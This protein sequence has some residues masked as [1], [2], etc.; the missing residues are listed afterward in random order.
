MTSI[1][2]ADY[3]ANNDDAPELKMPQGTF[4]ALRR[5][6]AMVFT[7]V[8]NYDSRLTDAINEKVAADVKKQNEAKQAEQTKYSK[9]NNIRSFR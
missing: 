5:S 3:T 1:N 9:I 7:E 4:Q 2:Y 8:E 6:N